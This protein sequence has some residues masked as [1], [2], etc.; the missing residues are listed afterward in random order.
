MNSVECR[1]VKK[2]RMKVDERAIK[3]SGNA[4]ST[5]R[6]L[7]DELYVCAMPFDVLC[8]SMKATNKTSI[9]PFP[10]FL[11]AIFLTLSDRVLKCGKWFFLLI[12]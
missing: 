10:P 4:P 7:Y 2:V 9:Y 1:V 8:A 3:N 12:L 11:F 5:F 6:D